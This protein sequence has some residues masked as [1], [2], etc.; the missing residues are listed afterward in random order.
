MEV[1]VELMARYIEN[2]RR[3]LD[4]CLDF[5]RQHDFDKIAKVGHQLKGN[6]STF[7]HPELSTIGKNLEEAAKVQDT[8]SLSAALK[9]FRHWLQ[10]VS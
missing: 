10:K 1:P 2:R 7:G 6:G 9:D 4:G 3:D 8:D 5:Y